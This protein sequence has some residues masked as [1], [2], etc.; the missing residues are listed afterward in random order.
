MPVNIKRVEEM[1]GY[2]NECAEAVRGLTGELERMNGIREHMIS[3]FQY[4]GSEAWYEDRGDADRGDA[5][6]EQSGSDSGPEVRPESGLP[7]CG[8]L[9]E[10][11]VY[12]VI[13]DVRQ[14]AFDM[15]ELAADILRNRI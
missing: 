8:V 6:R 3:L 2:L 7:P 5:D 9:T 11:L 1:E 10:D 4:Y 13:T 14:A 12:D 15:L